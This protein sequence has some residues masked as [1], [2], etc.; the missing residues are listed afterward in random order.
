MKISDALLD[1]PPSFGHY[2]CAILEKSHRCVG[3]TML[4]LRCTIGFGAMIIKIDVEQ[5]FSFTNH[6]SNVVALLGKPYRVTFVSHRVGMVLKVG[7]VG[8][9]AFFSAARNQRRRKSTEET[10]TSSVFFSVSC[11]TQKY[12]HRVGVSMKKLSSPRSLLG[13]ASMLVLAFRVRCGRCE[14]DLVGMLSNHKCRRQLLLSTKL[15]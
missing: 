3:R 1:L 5:W 14:N 7:L 11:R 2:E 12:C 9:A 8:S 10:Q 4:F 15:I 6:V 13:V